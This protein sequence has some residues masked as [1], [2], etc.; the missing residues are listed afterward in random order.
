M[1]TRKEVD[2]SFPITCLIQSYKFFQR[3]RIQ[4]DLDAQQATCQHPSVLL[5]PPAQVLTEAVFTGQ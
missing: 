2:I 1:L 4:T 3:K 5:R